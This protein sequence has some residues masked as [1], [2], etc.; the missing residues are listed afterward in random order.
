MTKSEKK[1][2]TGFSASSAH[3]RNLEKWAL[4]IYQEKFQVIF[5]PE[6]ARGWGVFPPPGQK[7]DR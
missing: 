5:D 6:Q 7:A 2:T 1:V 4:I 3:F